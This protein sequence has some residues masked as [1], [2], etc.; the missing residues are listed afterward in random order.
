MNT[1]K[2]NDGLEKAA[3]NV[4]ELSQ[5]RQEALEVLIDVLSDTPFCRTQIKRVHDG[6]YVDISRVLDGTE[7]WLTKAIATLLERPLTRPEC[8]SYLPISAPNV[9]GASSRKTS[10]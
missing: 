6:Y 3:A 4:V 9:K 10:F 8:E 5:L 7:L 1:S 2:K